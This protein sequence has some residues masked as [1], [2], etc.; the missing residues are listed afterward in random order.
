MIL[1]SKDML[2]GIE[3]RYYDGID[4]N[5]LFKHPNDGSG[6]FIFCFVTNWVSEVKKFDRE[7]KID[8]LV[9]NKPIKDLDMDDLNNNYICIYQTNGDLDVVYKTVKENITKKIGRPWA[10]VEC[11][12]HYTGPELG[13]IATHKFYSKKES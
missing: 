8:N 5:K 10:P 6:G 7:S 9:D 3:V 2:E 11:I 1:I 12:E 13:K 4:F